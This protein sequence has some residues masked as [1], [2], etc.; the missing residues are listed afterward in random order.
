MPRGGAVGFCRQTAP[1]SGLW[2][3]SVNEPGVAAASRCMNV[4][5]P[6]VVAP[7][8]L[9]CSPVYIQSAGCPCAVATGT[10]SATVA[11]AT[12][13]RERDP[14]MLSLLWPLR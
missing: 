14:L 4:L 9:A 3:T 11:T 13:Q 2:P 10:A 8:C 12:I 5:T 1:P 7:I 6:P